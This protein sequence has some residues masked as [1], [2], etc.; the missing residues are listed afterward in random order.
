MKK[1][2]FLSGKNVWMVSSDGGPPI[3]F[4]KTK[5]GKWGVAWFS[6]REIL[7]QI[8]GDRNFKILDI[9]TG[10]ETP[11][12][13]NDSVGWMYDPCISSDGKKVALHWNR[14]FEDRSERGLW[15]ISREDSKQT[16]LYKGFI[17]P[18]KWSADG[19]WI[20]AIETNKKLSKILKI[21]AI[22][23]KSEVIIS[24]PLPPNSLVDITSG[25]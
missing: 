5:V 12:V 3:S 11:L 21:S 15:V 1:L 24:L 2:A 13:S 23:G 22:D 17:D 16:L 7:Y 18:L 20:Y 4:P 6:K 19:N 14:F 9:N 25:W 8:P 10:E